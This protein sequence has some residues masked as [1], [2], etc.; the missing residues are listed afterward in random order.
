MELWF[1][2][3]SLNSTVWILSIIP[4]CFS[5]EQKKTVCVVR[6]HE[7]SALNAQFICKTALKKN[8][9][10]QLKMNKQTKK[11]NS[12]FICMHFV[13]E[14]FWGT[15]SVWVAS[16]QNRHMWTQTQRGRRYIIFFLVFISHISSTSPV[17]IN[18]L[19]KKISMYQACLFQAVLLYHNLGRDK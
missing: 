12:L 14:R 9:A 1:T 3:R 15:V 6:V 13:N 18:S 2:L 4:C 5:K 16:S 10:Y 17:I 19:T 8:K 7:S 11:E